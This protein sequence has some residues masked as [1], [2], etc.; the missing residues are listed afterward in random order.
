MAK[1]NQ[2]LH[3]LDEAVKSKVSSRLKK[4]EGQVRALSKMV[5]DDVYCDDILNLFASVKSAL[6]GAQDVILEEHIRHCI[7]EEMSVDRYKAT[8][9]LIGIFKKV[10]K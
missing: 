6:N 4:I 1:E 10:S 9:E 8:Q 2:H 5:A 7:A 3:Q